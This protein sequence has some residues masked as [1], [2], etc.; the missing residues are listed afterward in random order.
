M[1]QTCLKTIYEIS[2]KDKKIL[3]VGSDLGPGVMENFKK[4]FPDRFFMEGVA[5][6]SIIGM[7]AGLAMEGFKPYVNTIATFLTRR[8]YEQ[9]FVDLC[10]HKLPV[11][12]V[13]NGGGLVYAPLGPT[14]QSIEDISIL[15]TIPNM[16]IISPCDSVE[17][18]KLIIDTKNLKGPLYIRIAKGN[19]TIITH[20]KEKIKFGKSIT[21]IVPRKFLILSTGVMTQIAIKAA[22]KI[23]KRHGKNFCGVLHFATIKPLDLHFIKK[24][25]PIVKKII[26]IEE[27]VLAGGFGSLILEETNKLFP[28]IGGKI[29]RIGLEDEFIKHYGTQEELLL[30]YKLNEENIIKKLF[31]FK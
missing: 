10:L 20:S 27:N 5:E 21:K 24:W 3:F 16:S 30:K 17:M 1:R 15:R 31:K 19:D 14:H 22:E 4:K 6:Q 2:K 29:Q 13:A 11:R 26:T 9:V 28:K 7:A 23:N 12:L 8:C 25:F 18:K